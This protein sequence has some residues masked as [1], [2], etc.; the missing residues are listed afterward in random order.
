M[1]EIMAAATWS[2]IFERVQRIYN[3]VLK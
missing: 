1:A 2:G 3:L